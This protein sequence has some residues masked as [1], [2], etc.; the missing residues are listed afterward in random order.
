MALLRDKAWRDVLATLAPALDVLVL[1]RPPTAPPERAWDLGEAA[2]WC[3][4]RGIAARAEADFGAA[5]DAA[6]REARTVLVTGSFHTVGDA[7]AR[8]P[9]MAPLG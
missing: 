1:T 4:E 8:L 7:M 9:G 5:L 3:A 6:Q 2:R